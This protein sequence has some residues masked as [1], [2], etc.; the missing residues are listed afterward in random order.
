MW[1]SAR[2]AAS[3]IDSVAT[4]IEPASGTN[5]PVSNWNSVDLPAPL[6]PSSTTKL[7]GCSVSDTSSS[8]ARSP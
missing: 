7:A 8:A 6:G 3:R 2:V 1:R 4:S 5:R